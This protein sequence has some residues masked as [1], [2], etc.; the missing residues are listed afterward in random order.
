MRHA[1]LATATARHPGCRDCG[2][3]PL[4]ADRH[5]H[6]T[7]TTNKDTTAA[8]TASAPHRRRRRAARAVGAFEVHRDRR[9]PD[10][11]RHHRR[12]LRRE[13]RRQALRRGPLV[14]PHGGP[15]R[16]SLVRDG[17]ARRHPHNGRPLRAG[18]RDAQFD[19]QLARVLRQARELHARRPRARPLLRRR[20]R[21]AR[22][23]PLGASQGGR[24]ARG[25]AEARLPRL[26]L[27]LD[28]GDGQRG[29]VH[30]QERRPDAG[31]GRSAAV[32]RRD[33]GGRRCGRGSQRPR[34]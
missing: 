18:R 9:P 6:H 31:L 16:E 17:R 8:T 3:A 29:V 30:D 23:L 33:G 25:A 21:V 10:L 24:E 1:G 12:R 34:Q 13:H 11:P 32:A 5:A 2:R 4:G 7:A 15:R 19:R 27:T 22:R 20:R 26:Q 28:T 14:R